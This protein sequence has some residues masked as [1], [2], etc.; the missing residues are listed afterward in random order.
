MRS[1]I[2]YSHLSFLLLVACSTSPQLL[3]EE[4][5]QLS[6]RAMGA[7]TIDAGPKAG[8]AFV[9]QIGLSRFAVGPGAQQT[10]AAG[11]YRVAGTEGAFTLLQT[12]MAMANS[13][14]SARVRQRVGPLP[15]GTAAHNQAVRDYFVAAGLPAGHR[16][17]AARRDHPGKRERH[18]CAA[19]QH[20]RE[21]LRKRR[22]RPDT[23][24]GG[25]RAGHVQ[26]WL[27][28]VVIRRR[29]VGAG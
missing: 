4:H 25:Y 13:N 22:R 28:S 17:N 11:A 18:G 29:G 8:A 2:L 3:P 20:A 26:C 10:S 27:G 15:G 21:H 7:T 16:W 23:R 19:H 12:G 9:H 24:V 14:V 5:V 1:T 6:T